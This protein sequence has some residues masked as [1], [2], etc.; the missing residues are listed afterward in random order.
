[1]QEDNFKVT[2]WEVTGKVDYEKLIQQFGTQK[3]S[4]S[5]MKD[6]S[7]VS[8]DRMHVML[9]R[10]IFF[11]HRD[12][13]LILKDY[14]EGRGFFLYTG[15]APSMGMH[16]GHLVPFLFTKWLQDVFDVNVYIEITDDEKFM[17]NQEYTLK[18]TS[19]WAHQNILD[20]IAVGFN[21]DKTFIFKDTEYI[22]NMYPL[23]AS[24]AKR[25]NFSQVKATFGLDVSSNIGILFYPA[26]QIVPTMFEKARCLIPA[27]ID[28]DPYWRLQRDLAESLGYHKAAEIHSK[29]LPPLASSDGKMSSSVP[30]SAVYLSDPPKTVEK[31]IMK[32]A[33]SGGQATTELQRKLGADLNVDVPY[34]WLYYIF[35][36]DDEEMKRITSE[37]SSGK[38]LTGEIKKILAQKVNEL[39]E[40]HRKRRDMSEKMYSKF[41]YEGKLAKQ[42]WEKIHS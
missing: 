8:R 12:L 7:K 26:I 28:Q 16:I 41:L 11:S 37:Y 29:F 18:Q 5:I 31:K 21:P 4:E 39:L 32:Y 30:E 17:R 23:V 9:R 14:R 36:E 19:E 42:M 1:M 24:I 10:N 38:M 6:I 20:I 27:A 3:I 25:L 35:E 22:R 34:Q 13:D 2:P 33:F 40:E 15:R